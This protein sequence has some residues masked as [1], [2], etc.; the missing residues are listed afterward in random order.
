M[1]IVSISNIYNRKQQHPKTKWNLKSS[2]RSSLDY[3]KQ[4]AVFP[5]KIKKYFLFPN[6][7]PVLTFGFFSCDRHKLQAGPSI[8]SEGHIPQTKNL[9][10]LVFFQ[11]G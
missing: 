1:E 6:L 10:K 4:L 11:K 7:G 8:Q 9:F 5:S 2:R 3:L